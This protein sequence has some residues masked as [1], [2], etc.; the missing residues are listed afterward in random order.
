MPR[1]RN[2]SL[3]GNNSGSGENE[4]TTL[5][6]HTNLD[7]LNPAERKIWIAVEL[8]GIGV[9]EY[10]REQGWSSPGTA[11]NLLSRAREKIDAARQ[12]DPDPDPEGDSQGDE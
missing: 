5:D 12:S 4:Q 8:Q 1:T 7:V 3:N 2:N 6:Q 11:S 9:R 10:Q